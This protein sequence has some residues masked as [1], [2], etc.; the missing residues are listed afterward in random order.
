MPLDPLLVPF[1][2]STTMSGESVVFIRGDEGPAA[3]RLLFPPDV[4]VAVTSAA[5]DVIY[6]E[7]VDYEVDFPAG[8]IVRMPGSRIPETTRAAIAAADGALTHDR[9]VAVTYTHPA[10]PLMWN[11]PPAGT[12]SRVMQR[13]QRREPLTIA[14]TGDSISEG[15]DASGFYGIPPNQPPFARLVA[16][17]LEQDFG[18]PVRLHNLATAGSTAA[19]ALWETGRIAASEPDLV[20]V[21]FGMNDACYAEAGEFAANVSSLLCRVRDDVP[22]AEFVIVSPMLPTPECT[23]VVPARVLDYRAALNELTGDGV[24]LADVTGLWSA[25]VA[26][27]DPHDL[28]GNGLNHPNDFGHRIYAQSILHQ[29]VGGIV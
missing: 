6:V 7:G 11:P 26:R 9:I 2:L 29:L 27:K 4:V 3:S 15:Y 23:W 24:V 22:L 18:T 16:T 14:V 19:D 8:R 1:W 12:I 28:S 10:A 13:L 21:A 17:A 25:M 5:A 20:I